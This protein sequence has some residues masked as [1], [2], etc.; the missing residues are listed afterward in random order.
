MTQENYTL[1]N[2]KQLINKLALLLQ[3]IPYYYNFKGEKIET[4]FDTKLDIISSMG[5]EIYEESLEYWIDYLENGNWKN[6]VDPVYVISNSIEISI[7]LKDI[8]KKKI[9]IEIIP[10]REIG[11]DGQAAKFEFSLEKT[12]IKESKIIRGETFFKYSVK[13]PEYPIGY[14]RLKVISDEKQ[15]ESI[16]IVAPDECFTYFRERTWG[17][18]LNLW[19]LRGGNIESDFSHVKEFA[20]YIKKIGGFIS[21]NPLHL[22]NPED[23]YGISPYSALSRQFKTPLYLSCVSVEEK[24]QNFFKYR[25]IWKEKIFKLKERYLNLDDYSEEKKEFI[26]Y[27]NSLPQLFKDDLKYF[28]VYCFLREKFDR[29]WFFWDESFRNPEREVIER[30]YCENRNE[31]MFYE[32][33]Q[34]LVERE[35]E[36]FNDYELCLDLGFGSTKSS[37]DVWINR[38]MYALNSEYGAP[39]DEFNPKGQKWGFPPVI[40]FKLRENCYL[41]FIKILRANMKGK[42]LRIDHALGLFRAFWIPHGKS[43]QEG[44]YLRYPWDELLKIICLESQLNKTSIIGE[45]LGTAEDWMREELGKRKISSWRVFYFEKD[46]S[47]YKDQN[48]YP[49]ESLC[50]ITTHDL[51]TLKGFWEGKDIRLR[52]NLSIFD[53]ITFNYAMD[54]RERD[55]ARIVEL[56]LKYGLKDREFNL[57]DLL[58]SIIKFLSGTK[59]R[60]LLLYPE[61]LLLLEDQTNLPGTSLEYPNWQRKLPITVSEFI[62]SSIMREI[63]VILKETGR[64]PQ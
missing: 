34:W 4:P 21:I 49:E 63:E 61:D 6:L 12:D 57:N 58:I 53:D 29:D 32:Y 11:F 25:E 7:C 1:K 45:D 23:I 48:A 54:E 41:P 43:P 26:E 52:K 17:F 38:E 9:E 56:L 51:P 59:A 15:S 20:S 60:Y 36:S 40:P 47:D 35:L 3:I 16:L 19:S 50:S 44:A 8:S 18:H 30:I 33:L 37:F 14:Y 28:S 13:L 5:I 24:D 31:V 46:L 22:N 2:L 64:A 27:R 62:H 39:P 55:K 42:L 10:L